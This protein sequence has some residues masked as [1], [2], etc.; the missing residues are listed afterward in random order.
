[1]IRRTFRQIA[2]VLLNEMEFRLR[3]KRLLS[4]PRIV[5]VVI[6]YACNVDCTFCQFRG[7]KKPA[8][9]SI[10]EF[11]KIARCL[12]KTASEVRFCSCGEPYLHPQFIDLCRLT[13]KETNLLQVLSNGMPLTESSSETIIGEH[14]VAG[15]GFSYD[16]YKDETVSAIRRGI[17]PERVKK[18]IAFFLRLKMSLK[19]PI[20]T[21]IRFALMRRNLSE[22]PDAIGFWG[23]QGIDSFDCNYLLITRDIPRSESVYDIP[24]DVMKV[25]E[26]CIKKSAQ[27]PH[28]KLILPQLSGT[29]QPVQNCKYPWVFLMV[30]SEG[31][32]YPCYVAW[33]NHYF[34]TLKNMEK[35]SFRR[36]WNTAKWSELRANCNRLSKPNDRHQ[37]S[38]CVVRRGYNKF[39]NHVLPQCEDYWPSL[40]G[41]HQGT[42]L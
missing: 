6:S 9:V 2:N 14:L 10:Q 38:R 23:D 16:G 4:P 40:S 27:Y 28:M 7:Y 32:A 37:C 13:K 19:A 41:E 30:D 24:K 34:G 31:C 25:F 18:N 29:D 20:H 33:P 5:D 35:S 12:F 26:T 1:M 15:H 17:D 21:T 42:D 3:G 22:L 8:F 39:E 36:V 11:Q